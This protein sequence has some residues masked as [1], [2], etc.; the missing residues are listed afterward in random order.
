MSSKHDIFTKIYIDY[1]RKVKYFA[2]SYLKDLPAAESITHD[3]FLT[4]WNKWEH[5]NI[6]NNIT[7]YLMVSAKNA[8]LN[9]IRKETHLT[10]YKN[11]TQ[12]F[13]KNTINYAALAD[14]SSTALY[15]KEIESIVLKALEEVSQNTKST[16]ILSRF[17]Q[18]KYEEIAKLQ[19]ISVKTV[20][21]RISSVLKLLRSYLI[22]YLTL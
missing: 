7:A 18:M 5:I 15:S 14:D 16:F 12:K 17:K 2:Y 3:V 21:F 4:L 6:D 20:E 19:G 22:N 13:T 11:Y 10:D 1:S 8:C 9:Y